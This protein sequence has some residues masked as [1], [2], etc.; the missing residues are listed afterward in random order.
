MSN[1]AAALHAS[2]ATTGSADS[3]R[4]SLELITFAREGLLG[5]LDGLTLA[6]V[7]M[8]PAGFNNNLAWQLAHVIAVEQKYIYEKG[9][10]PVNIDPAIIEAYGNGTK[11]EKDLT[12]A[13]LDDFKKLAIATIE[14]LA[15][16]CESGHF[17]NYAPHALR[18]IQ[19]QNIDDALQFI[20]FH[21]GLH[22]G[23]ARD[24][25]RAVTA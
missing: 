20:L 12:Q 2:P 11:P 19:I 3:R 7:N 14:K 21:E 17:D 5:V 8:V 23:A 15:A 10:L 18:H 22:V 9:G 16:D 24:L 6:Q 4:K 13:E 1:L 25:R